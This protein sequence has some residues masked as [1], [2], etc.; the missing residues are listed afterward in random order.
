M[1]DPEEREDMEG[2]AAEF[3][4]GTLSPAERLDVVYR[5]RTDPEL[6][7]A[8]EVW[9]E[10]LSPLIEAVNP[11]DPP[12]GIEDRV[13]DRVSHIG[14][15]TNIASLQE[16]VRRW[17]LSSIVLGAVSAA[18]AAIVIMIAPGPGPETGIGRHYVATL[19]AQ[20]SQPA[21][22]A[23]ID[24][25]RGVIAIRRVN[26]EVPIGKNY[27]LWA[28][29]GGRA[30]PQSL[31]VIDAS[32]NISPESFGSLGKKALADTLLAVTIEPE[33]G[34]PNGQPSGPPVFVGKLIATE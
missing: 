24:L 21:F 12:P 1:A 4:L 23:T 10:R 19:Q 16:A 7:R 27:E 34:S 13:L 22:V 33:G 11:I 32:L 2:L 9:N 30:A 17:R 25:G 14:Q 20:G 5:M 15:D 6:K 3:V 26:A 8:V 28:I 31:G 18:L 29:G